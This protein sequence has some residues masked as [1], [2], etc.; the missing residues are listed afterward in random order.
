MSGRYARAVCQGGVSGRY[1]TEGDEDRCVLC[2]DER[3]SFEDSQIV[4]EDYF[5][6]RMPSMH[7]FANLAWLLQTVCLSLFKC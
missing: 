7:A 1:A 3:W 6:T 2:T 5:N 4:D